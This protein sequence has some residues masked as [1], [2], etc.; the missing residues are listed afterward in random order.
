MKRNLPQETVDYLQSIRR[1]DP[2]KFY[3]S[4]KG[5]NLK[6][7]W[8]L[9]SIASSM[10]VS[11]SGVAVWTRKADSIISEDLPVVPKKT[12]VTPE[13]PK[14]KKPNIS[15]SDQER[16]A[17]L[18]QEAS[19]VRRYT[20]QDH[21]A[22]KAAKELEDLLHF[23]YNRGATLSQLSQIANVSRRA[24]AQRLEKREREKLA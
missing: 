16:I 12:P 13:T 1:S 23:Y 14:S 18:T 6:N 21:P 15:A 4:I 24:I 19:V 20:A 10:D 2:E 22:R 17:R 8:S 7:G 9:R 11:A 5:L 3:A